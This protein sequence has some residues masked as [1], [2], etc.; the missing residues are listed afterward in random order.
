MD[1]QRP[2]A[3]LDEFKSKKFAGERSGTLHLSGDGV[4][5]ND[6]RALADRLAEEA[7]ALRDRA[8]KIESREADRSKRAA[9]ARAIRFH[10]MRADSGASER[11]IARGLASQLDLSEADAV[12]VLREE[13]AHHRRSLKAQRNR[14][15]LQLAWK[16]KTNAEIARRFHLSEKHVSRIVAARLRA[17]ET[18][19]DDA[20][21][22]TDPV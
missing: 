15:I 17:F 14:A 18:Q 9:R 19:M 6:M 8:R 13:R 21:R 5:P 1:N 10:A 16:G 2:F 7:R 4:S 12:A 20:A 3:S 22:R 11:E